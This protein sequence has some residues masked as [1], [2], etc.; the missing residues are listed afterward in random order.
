MKQNRQSLSLFSVAVFVSVCAVHA[1]VFYCAAQFTPTAV[2]SAQEKTVKLEVVSLNESKPVQTIPIEPPV[3]QPVKIPDGQIKTDSHI[4]PKSAKELTA[5]KQAQEKQLAAKSQEP[6]KAEQKPQV[7]QQQ[8]IQTTQTE[9][10]GKNTGYS[11]TSLAQ[12]D[13]Y[14]TVTKAGTEK[15][16]GGSDSTSPKKGNENN[17][18][19]GGGKTQNARVISIDKSFP[20]NLRRQDATGKVTFNVL[21]GVNGRAKQVSIINTTNSKFNTQANRSARGGRYQSAMENG[22]T[23]EK[24]ITFSIDYKLDGVV[25]N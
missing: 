11:A 23:V 24:R 3:A 14:K 9:Q 1:G 8:N 19:V 2:I 4:L 16:G 18:G 10:P 6:I 21:V 15:T 7:A 25:V 13:S 17:G 5:P 22:Q 12:G 20:E